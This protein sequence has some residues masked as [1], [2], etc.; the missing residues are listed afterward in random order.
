[1]R[2]IYAMALVKPGKPLQA[3][4]LLRAIGLQDNPG[5]PKPAEPQGYSRKSLILGKTRTEWWWMQS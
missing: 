3:I 4:E 2:A 5:R 1:M